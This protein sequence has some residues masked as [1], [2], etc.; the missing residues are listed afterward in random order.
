VR[1]AERAF[2]VEGATLLGEALRAGAVVE[3]VYVAP[4]AAGAH[5]PAEVRRAWEAG[6]RVH[7]LAPGVL[8]RIAGTITPQ[9]VL[10]V[11]AMPTA[12][13]DDLRGPGPVVVCVD[14]RDPGNL[15]TVLRSAE[16]AGAAGVVCCEGTVDVHNPKSVRASAGA[17]FL[18]PV[19]SGGDPRRVLD[20]LAEAGRRR[21]G[22]AA[23]VGTAYTDADLAGPLAIVLGNEAS[24]LSAPLLADLDEVVHV[25]IEG[26][27]E[28]LNVGMACAVLCF[29][30]ARQRRRR[31][32][33]APRALEGPPA[34]AGDGR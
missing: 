15:G 3:S 1:E 4:G 24:G 32:G 31:V 27:S 18:I 2:V 13:L 12:T 17:V 19:V 22:T 9:P 33:A 5:E 20:Q 23:G 25:P 6:V 14:V 30:A 29:E 7:D 8:E 26:R 34:Q 21:L 10:A 28:S 11:V 16:A